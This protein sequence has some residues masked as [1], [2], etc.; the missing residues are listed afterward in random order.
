M[1]KQIVEDIKFQT[2]VCDLHLAE[3]E[4]TLKSFPQFP[5]QSVL[6]LCVLTGRLN[7]LTSTWNL[8]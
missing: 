1:L 6:K 8:E 2:K 7:N 4:T 5:D 3:N